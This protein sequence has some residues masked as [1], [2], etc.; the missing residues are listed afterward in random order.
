MNRTSTFRIILLVALSVS[1]NSLNG[2]I[3][4][5]KRIKWESAKIS[6][7]LTWKSSHTFF[8][9]SVP[10]NIN[11][12]IINT[13]KRNISLSYNPEKN[14]I[15]SDQA[16]KA[17]AIA[18]V[19]AGF[20]NIKDGGSVTYIRTGGKIAD[21]DTAKKWARNSNMTGALVVDKK[22]HVSIDRAMTNT[23]YDSHQEYPEVLVTGPLLL[24]G[25]EKIQLPQTP[26]VNN[27]HPRTAIGKRGSHRIV[28]VTLDGRTDQAVGMTLAELTDLFISLHCRDAVNLD[29]GGSTTM[30]ILGKP[31]E[32]VVNMPCDNKKFDHEGA[33]AVSDILIIR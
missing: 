21:T 8:Y 20:F 11:I 3:K 33:R 27:I 16:E 32:G 17:G 23:W 6:P 22:S 24:S 18:A 28:L 25:K 9:D 30:W 1:F 29:G 5:F 19:N 7:G 2:Q 13:Q 10:Q 31:F 4:G 14:I 15:V 12:L 26:L